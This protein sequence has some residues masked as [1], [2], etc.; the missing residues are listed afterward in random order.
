LE[1]PKGTWAALG[2]HR[3]MQTQITSQKIDFVTAPATSLTPMAPIDAMPR[4]L[5]VDNQVSDFLQYRMTLAHTLREAGFDVHVAVPEE[6]GLEAISCQGIPV[7]TFYLRR[8]STR[9]LDELRCW[10]SLLRLYRRLQP[11]LVHHICLKPTLY[12]GIAARIAGVPA[13]VN[14][15]T[16]L[17]HL[18]TTRTVKTRVLW[19]IVARGLGFSFRHRNHRVILQ[20]P[21]DRDCL[22][23]SGVLPG[24]RAVIIKG[25][26]VNLSLFTPEPEPVG[27]PV[28]LMASR[29]LWTKGVGEFVAAAR[30]L[31]ARGSR[32]RFLLLGEPDPG[33]PSAVP[34]P[35]LEHWRDAGDVEWLGWCHDMPAFMAQSHIVCLPSSYGEGIPRILVEAAASGR[36]IVTADSPGCREVVRHGQNGLLVPVRDGEALIA[37]LAQLIENAPVRAAMG[38]RGREIAVIEFSLQQVIDANLA[39]YRS[40]LA[41]IPVLRGS[42]AYA[43]SGLP[44][45]IHWEKQ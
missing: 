32:A 3:L 18:F 2:H 8:K 6:P 35:T 24:D 14:M 12:G 1:L 22:L 28:V 40:L 16:G 17:G 19:W 29:L 41:A 44:T 5:F 27:P 39:V 13:L 10:I 11:T 21:D 45:A 36:P 38:T 26:G 25:S 33:H 43:T 9:P 15:L 31:R 20:N 42:A 37:A 34:L 30:A 7:H 4:V 23:A